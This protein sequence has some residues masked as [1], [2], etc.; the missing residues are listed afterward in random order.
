MPKSEWFFQYPSALIIKSDFNE[1]ANVLSLRISLNFLIIFANKL[2][3]NN[4]SKILAAPA[5]L[6]NGEFYGLTFPK[7]QLS[8]L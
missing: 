4:F 1:C 6:I 5:I 2:S 7:F 8:R 3:K